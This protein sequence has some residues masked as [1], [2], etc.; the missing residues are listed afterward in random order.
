MYVNQIPGNS[1]R[2]AV[3]GHSSDTAFPNGGQVYMYDWNSC[4][5]NST[6]MRNEGAPTIYDLN[7]SSWNQE[8]IF[9]GENHLIFW[10]IDLP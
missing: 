2:L 9:P 1:Q 7:G 10:P 8:V 5:P 6:L 3:S 4:T